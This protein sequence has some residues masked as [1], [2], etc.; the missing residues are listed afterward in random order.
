MSLLVFKKEHHIY[1]K[2]LIIKY[3]FTKAVQPN[4]PD[5]SDVLKPV[6]ATVR[7]PDA[8]RLRCRTRQNPVIQ[9]TVDDWMIDGKPPN[10]DDIRTGRVTSSMGQLVIQNTRQEDSGTYTCILRNTAGTVNVTANVTVTGK[11]SY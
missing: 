11:K 1:T 4:P 2:P 10:A 9:P 3:F 8:V 7:A 5:I 6:N